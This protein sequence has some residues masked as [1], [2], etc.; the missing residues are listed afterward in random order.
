MGSEAILP[1]FGRERLNGWL[2]L[3]RSS[4]GA[5]FEQR[6][7]EELTQLASRFPLPL[8]TPCFTKASLWKRRSQK[9]F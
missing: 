1:L 9:I 3:G 7:I 5:P 6:D 2:C 8:K 4:S